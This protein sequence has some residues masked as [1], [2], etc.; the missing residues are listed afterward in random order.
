MKILFRIAALAAT[1][2]LTAGC[3]NCRSYQKKTRRPLEGTEWQ[4]I[5][6]DGRS[7]KAAPET[8]VL[9]LENGSVSGAGACNRLMGSYKTGERRALKIGPLATTK[10]AC[11]NLDQEQQFL[12][13]LESTT[14]YD[15]DGPMLLLL[16]NGEL[17]AVLQALP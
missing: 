3:C 6:L 16:S 8:F 11:P 14:H 9:K 17:H 10:M 2:A 1:V 5:Q 13:A 15:M 7:V 4:L 12:R